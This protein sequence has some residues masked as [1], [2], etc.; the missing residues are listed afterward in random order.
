MHQPFYFDRVTGEMPMP[1]VRLHTIKGY[2]DMISL[3][4]DFPGVKA[5]FNLVPSLLTQLSAYVSGSARDLYYEYTLIPAEDLTLEQKKFVLREFFQANWD[6]MIRPHRRYWELMN[7]RGLHL[8]PGPIDDETVAKFNTQAFR[9]IQVWFNL[10]WFGYRAREKYPVLAELI[11]KGE[12]FTEDEKEEVL[13]MQIQVIR[14][15]VPLYRHMQNDG[16]VELTTSPFYHPILPLLCDSEFT[17][18]SLP[19]AKLPERF[20]HPEDAREQIRKAVAYHQETFHRLPQG[21]WPSEGS[22]CPELVPMLGEAGIRWIATDEGI[23]AR[24]LQTW[25]IYEHLYL[26][27]RARFQDAEV[28]IVF[29]DRGLSDLISFGYSRNRPDEASDDL[30]TRL[31]R[32]AEAHWRPDRQPLVSIIL[33]GENAWEYYPCGGKEFL[34]RLYEKL[35]A[36]DSIQSV[37]FGEFLAENPPQHTL[38]NLYTGS[39]IG[40]NFD[41]WIGEHEEN[42]AWDCLNHTRKFLEQAK[43]RGGHDGLAEAWESFYAAEGSDWF[44]WYGPDFSTDND[45]E[46]DRLF[47]LH[48]QN[49]YKSMNEEIPHSLSIPLLLGER[50]PVGHAPVSLIKPLINGRITDFYEWKGAGR[51]ECAR[52]DKAIA[53]GCR[54]VTHIY[55]GFDL[56][57][58]YLRFDLDTSTPVRPEDA[59]VQLHVCFNSGQL[60][61]LTLPLYLDRAERESFFLERS[62]D[63]LVF[64]KVREYDSIAWNKILELSIPFADLGFQPRQEIEFFASLKNDKIEMMRLPRESNLQFTVPDEDFENEMWVV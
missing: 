49:V 62:G 56:E 28:N 21:M 9:D 34:S 20:R 41:I 36:D 55:Y 30:M 19:G 10:T 3:L 17:W 52:G 6:N 29:R 26:P 27:Y 14:D 53:L 63:G 11:R 60:Q 46:F 37:T 45:A 31:H 50:A 33:D 22:V 54:F 5:T 64:E 40:N 25:N 38:D 15:L 18:R 44:W 8:P 32:I 7:E 43:Q 12:Y 42:S 57:N 39:W 2:Y 16:R 48:L 61:R 1:W 59:S 47:R 24:S 13:S 58:L 4:E 51:Y 23:L 35:S